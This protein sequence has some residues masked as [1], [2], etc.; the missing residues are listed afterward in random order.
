MTTP[1][2]GWAWHSSIIWWFQNVQRKKKTKS[3]LKKRSGVVGECYLWH[4]VRIHAECVV[5][6]CFLLS[7]LFCFA[8]AAY[9]R[10]RGVFLFVLLNAPLEWGPPLSARVHCEPRRDPEICDT[11]KSV[12]LPRPAKTM[13]GL[14]AFSI[15]M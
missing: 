13:R 14:P 3:N 1:L 2:V 5:V 15:T 11:L 7:N 4:I 12:A 9:C 10:D 6:K 8:K